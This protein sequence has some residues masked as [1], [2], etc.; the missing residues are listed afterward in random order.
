MVHDFPR[1]NSYFIKSSFGRRRFKIRLLALAITTNVI[2]AFILLLIYP[3]LFGLSAFT[4]FA[5]ISIIA[6]FFDVPSLVANG[7]LIYRSPFL[8]SEQ[9]S[10][11]K[12][13]LHGGTLFDYY[14]SF[15]RSD[16]SGRRTQRVVCEFMRG[17]LKIKQAENSEIILRGTSYFI[18]EDT[19]HRFGFR[20]TGID[21][22]QWLILFL[23]L[24][25]LMASLYLLKGKLI[26]PKLSQIRTYEAKVCE[27]KDDEIKNYL[28]RLCDNDLS[29]G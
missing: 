7:K 4:V 6:P 2:F 16:G 15:I 20:K 9:E 11:G 21:S 26:F 18:G 14:F 10:N 29:K 27:V 28:K 23:N 17:L 25:H 24:P 3:P 8:L 13:V 22:V 12:I 19:A 1:E 5:T